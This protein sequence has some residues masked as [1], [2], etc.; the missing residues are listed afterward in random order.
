MY[1]MK[2]VGELEVK[3]HIYLIKPSQRIIPKGFNKFGV[4]SFLCSAIMAATQRNPPFVKMYHAI[5]HADSLVSRL[6]CI[7]LIQLPLLPV[8]IFI[9]LQIILWNFFFVTFQRNPPQWVRSYGRDLPPQ[10][11]LVMP[12]GGKWDVRL[13]NVENGCYFRA[14]WS[15][16]VFA[17]NINIGDTLIFTHAGD[18]VFQVIRTCALTGCPPLHDYD[19]MKLIYTLHSALLLHFVIYFCT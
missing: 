1:M 6:G 19:G 3:E 10:C 12:H 4:I 17:N 16:F 5:T 15:V 2:L 8:R 9:L 7:S 18:G 14:G 13:L 11:F